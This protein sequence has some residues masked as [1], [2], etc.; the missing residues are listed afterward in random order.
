[1]SKQIVM[2]MEPIGTQFEIMKKRKRFFIGVI[3]RQYGKSTLCAMR[4]VIRAFEKSKHKKI[5]WWV[6][7]IIA[8]ARTQFKRICNDYEHMIKQINKSFLEIEWLTGSTTFFKGSDN[9][10]SL[11]GETLDGVT[12]DEC[13]VMHEAVWSEIVRPMLAVRSGWADFI[14]TPKGK[15]WFYD[16]YNTNDPDFDK[17]HAT[18]VDSPFFSEEEFNK[19]KANTSERTFRQEYLAEF[20]DSD[21]EVFRGINECIKGKLEEPRQGREYI[22][23]CDLAKHFDWTVV[24]VW[25]IERKHLVNYERFNKIDW[26]F[27]KKKIID[28]ANR[29][30]KS[31]VVLD[32]TGIGDPIYDDLNRAGLYVEGVKFTQPVKKNLIESMQIM[33][34]KQEVSFPHIP[35]LINELSVFEATRTAAGN[36]K[37]S[38]PE[39]YHDDIVISMALALSRL[40]EE[41][42]YEVVAL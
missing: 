26:L 13:G 18:S 16:L 4:H 24:T 35:E 32:S 20:L 10:D 38:A 28:T 17:Y 12:L 37:Y 19:I 34:E 42:R 9:Y 14:G 33:I 25:D 2:P 5:Y 11:R 3:G 36:T 6:S 29:Y 8:Q 40:R 23:G 41:A 31:R 30:N 7:P 39:G 15:N 27:Q 1:M 22:I 21:G